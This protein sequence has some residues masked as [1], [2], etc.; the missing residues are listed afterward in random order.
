[1]KK[2]F[3]KLEIK[4]FSGFRISQQHD[5]IHCECLRGKYNTQ[6]FPISIQLWNSLCQRAS[7]SILENPS[8]HRTHF[9]EILIQNEQHK[10][11]KP[12][13]IHWKNISLAPMNPEIKMPSILFY[14]HTKVLSSRIF[15]WWKILF[16]WKYVVD[17]QILTFLRRPVS[18][19]KSYMAASNFFYSNG[20]LHNNA[21][22]RVYINSVLGTQSSFYKMRPILVSDHKE[23]LW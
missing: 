20:H 5:N 10:S 16:W 21:E 15:F 7:I 11:W 4:H 6:V 17:L 12:R 19:G 13:K 18:E 22:L 3:G 9:G 2:K 8:T 1:M 14:R 23:S